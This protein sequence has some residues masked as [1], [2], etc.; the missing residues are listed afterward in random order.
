MLLFFCSQSF[1]MV[2]FRIQHSLSMIQG[3]GLSPKLIKDV[4]L[5]LNPIVMH[6]RYVNIMVSIL[7][8]LCLTLVWCFSVIRQIDQ[9]LQQLRQY[10]SL[11]ILWFYNAHGH[12]AMPLLDKVCI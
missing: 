3:G 7:T 11:K 2:W 6:S 10:G 1:R 8:H 4:C 5:A 9:Q 12:N